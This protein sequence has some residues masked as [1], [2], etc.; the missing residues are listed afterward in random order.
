[1]S[2][3]QQRRVFRG[4]SGLNCLAPFTMT[5]VIYVLHLV[6]YDERPY[7]LAAQSGTCGS[8]KILPDR[9]KQG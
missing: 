9:P 4:V 3:A 6:M 5:A 7:K 1:M 2:C 8:M